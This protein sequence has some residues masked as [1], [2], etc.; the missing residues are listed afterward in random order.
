MAEP[1][2]NAVVDWMIAHEQ[3]SGQ[4]VSAFWPESDHDE[5]LRKRLLNRIRQACFQR[6]EKGLPAPPRFSKRGGDTYQAAAWKEARAAGVVPPPPPP[7]PGAPPPLAQPPKVTR[8]RA[9]GAVTEPTPDMERADFLRA[10][11]ECA[12]DDVRQIRQ[13]GMWE[14]VAPADRRVSEIRLELDRETELERKTVKIVRTPA[15]LMKTIAERQTGI[16]LRAEIARRQAEKAAK[17][18]EKGDK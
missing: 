1:D 15:E 18:A 9:G 7:P 11:L 6:R 5:A 14:R 10:Q 13:R 12:L 8:G 17:D 16:Q 2:T 3:T 4:A